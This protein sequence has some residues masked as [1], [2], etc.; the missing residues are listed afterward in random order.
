MPIGIT[1]FIACGVAILTNVLAELCKF[2]CSRS[3][4][5]LKV[6]IQDDIKEGE[7]NPLKSEIEIR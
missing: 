5:K 3:S 7:V 6:V 2:M 4:C 1:I